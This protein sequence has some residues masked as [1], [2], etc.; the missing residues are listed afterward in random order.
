MKHFVLCLLV[1]ISMRSIQGHV[2]TVLSDVS[3][4]AGY[5]VE[6]VYPVRGRINIHV[7]EVEWRK[8]LMG[9][10]RAFDLSYE[11]DDSAKTIK[12]YRNR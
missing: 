12:V 3:A 11:I 5:T 2:R 7:V 4:Q 6:Y 8:I 1:L 9:I 10:G